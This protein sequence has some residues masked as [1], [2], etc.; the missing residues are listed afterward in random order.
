MLILIIVFSSC[1]TVRKS[2]QTAD[3]VAVVVESLVWPDIPDSDGVVSQSDGIVSMPID[4]WLAIID[5]YI[6][7]E[8]IIKSIEAAK[9]AKEESQ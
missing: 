6:D 9:I 8:A 5:Y 7:I 4:Y 3:L 2:D 1:V